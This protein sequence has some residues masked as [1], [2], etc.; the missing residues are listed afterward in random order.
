MGFEHDPGQEKRQ[1]EREAVG[2]F[3]R[4]LARKRQTARH[5]RVTEDDEP[6]E[7]RAERKEQR[8]ASPRH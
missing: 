6:P 7:P 3:H 5:P 2:E 4:L 8:P 1:D